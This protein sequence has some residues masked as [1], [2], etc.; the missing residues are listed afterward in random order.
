MTSDHSTKSDFYDRVLSGIEK[1][2][3]VFESAKLLAFH[4]T[5]PSYPFHV[6]IIPKKKI[7]DFMDPKLLEDNFISEVFRVAQEILKNEN[8]DSAGFRIV[9]N[10]GIYQESGHLHFHIISGSFKS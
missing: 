1:V 6:V 3:S 7:L 9:T 10:A 2:N 8:F 5:K 4:H